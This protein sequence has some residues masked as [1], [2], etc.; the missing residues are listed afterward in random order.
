MAWM[1]GKPVQLTMLRMEGQDQDGTARP[2]ADM[3]FMVLFDPVES[4]CV[5]TG[6]EAGYC[7]PGADVSWFVNGI[8]VFESVWTG[9]NRSLG[10]VY[11]AT[12]RM[13][14]PTTAGTTT[15]TAKSANSV[16]FTFTVSGTDTQAGSFIPSY[17]RCLNQEAAGT[18]SPNCECN[19]GSLTV[20]F[21][22]EPTDVGNGMAYYDVLVNGSPV[23]ENQVEST[24]DRHRDSVTIDCP[25]SGSVI[26]IRSS[27]GQE[28]S[29]TTSTTP[30]VPV[31]T[32]SC[33]DD[34]TQCFNNRIYSWCTEASGV[35]TWKDN[36]VGSCGEDPSTP[37]QPYIPGQPYTP[38][39]DV[40]YVPCTRPCTADYCDGAGNYYAC[41]EGCA[42]P[43]G[44]TC[45]P[46]TEEPAAPSSDPLK[47]L[48]NFYNNNKTVSIIGL[49]LLGGFIMFGNKE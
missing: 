21:T 27:S 30:S 22:V 37:D 41:Y 38:T 17:A 43:N 24:Y 47:T 23:L 13:V 33:N 36:G 4:G 11:A 16:T 28:T 19:G 8:Q 34:V 15:V 31:G 3:E 12:Y 2:G 1:Y 35:G 6:S 25:P 7:N 48:T 9:E 10:N 5:T 46:T 18:G 49:A 42:S 39:P 26:T 32:G 45:V 29:I 14:A 44:Q 20:Y 40:P